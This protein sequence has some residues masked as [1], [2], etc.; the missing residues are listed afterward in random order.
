MDP[1]LPVEAAME[2][3]KEEGEESETEGVVVL[4]EQLDLHKGDRI[5]AGDSRMVGGKVISVTTSQAQ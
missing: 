4:Q 5:S 1:K 3:V 2:E